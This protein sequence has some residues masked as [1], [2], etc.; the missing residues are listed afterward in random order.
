MRTKGF[1]FGDEDERAR[2]KG[3][4]VVRVSTTTSSWD[5]ILLTS[6]VQVSTTTEGTKVNYCRYIRAGQNS[7]KLSSS[8]ESAH[9]HERMVNC[10][11]LRKQTKANSTLLEGARRAAHDRS[12]IERSEEEDR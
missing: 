12:E 7:G 11:K 10:C 6:G 2:G 4:Q 3:S 8:L 5:C 1:E 9:C